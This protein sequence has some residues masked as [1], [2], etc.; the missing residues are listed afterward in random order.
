MGLQ[1]VGQDWASEHT[2][3]HMSEFRVESRNKALCTLGKPAGQVFR[4]SDILRS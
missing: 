3:T 4:W 1:R 2:G